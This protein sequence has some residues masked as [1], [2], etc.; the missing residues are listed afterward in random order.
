MDSNSKAANAVVHFRNA[1]AA[2]SASNPTPGSDRECREVAELIRAALRS[3][4]RMLR[5]FADVAEMGTPQQQFATAHFVCEPIIGLAGL[6][7]KLV[8]LASSM[9]DDFDGGEP[10][11]N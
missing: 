3:G 8:K 7:D 6:T 5:A 9:P 4:A 1:I 10:N 2:V 11:G